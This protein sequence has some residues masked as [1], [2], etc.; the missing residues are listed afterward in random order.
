[1]EFE[2]KSPL[3]GFEEVSIMKLIIIDDVFMKL[4]AK[5]EK[6]HPIFT[7]VNPYALREYKFDIPDVAIK[8]LEL[9]D[10]SNI[11]ILN[12]V[13]VQNPISSSTVNFAAPIIFNTD[14]K[15]MVQV[16]LDSSA[17][18]FGIAEPISNFL[19]KNQEEQETKA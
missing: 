11:S 18:D 7:L 15:T 14:N 19:K 8:A 13:V 6:E 1:M 5:N 16:I 12:I 4:Q 17:N 3:L 10:D 2:V 9:K